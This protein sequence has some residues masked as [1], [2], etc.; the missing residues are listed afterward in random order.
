MSEELAEA[1]A[2]RDMIAKVQGI[3][4]ERM[5]LNSQ[6]ALEVLLARSRGE[7]TPLHD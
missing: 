4:I 7:S 1:L 2:N 5:N 6:E 3:L